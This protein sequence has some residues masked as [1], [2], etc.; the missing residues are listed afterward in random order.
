MSNDPAWLTHYRIASHLWDARFWLKIS[1]A[2]VGK[3]AQLG[4]RNTTWS[5]SIIFYEISKTT[6]IMYDLDFSDWRNI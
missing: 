6:K 1:H 4:W 2:E 3:F 5:H